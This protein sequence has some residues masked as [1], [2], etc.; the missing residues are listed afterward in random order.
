MFLKKFYQHLC[1]FSYLKNKTNNCIFVGYQNKEIL[2]KIFKKSLYFDPLLKTPFNL[3][4]LLNSILIFFTN[5][6]FNF[7]KLNFPK[8][9]FIFIFFLLAYIRINKIKKVIFLNHYDKISKSLIPFLKNIQIY[10]VEHSLNFKMINDYKIKKLSNCCSLKNKKISNGNL[11]EIGSIKLL[12]YLN[13][14]KKW[15]CNI[16]NYAKNENLEL[17]YISTTSGYFWNYAKSFNYDLNLFKIDS[18]LR[19]V[20]PLQRLENNNDLLKVRFLDNLMV[21]NII[22]KLENS[23]LNISVINRNTHGNSELFKKEKNF[24]KENFK[25]INFYEFDEASKYKFLFESKQKIF[26]TDYSYF[27]FEAFSLNNKCIFFSSY[28]KKYYKE[29]FKDELFVDER[30]DVAGISKKIKDI[31]KMNFEEILEFKEN[32]K[33]YF[34]IPEPSQNK[35]NKLKKIVLS[36]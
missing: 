35:Y 16:K 11:I 18:F 28:M 15:D 33:K 8:S 13:K 9:Q 12:Y 1:S 30:T 36:N 20:K 7:K 17:V 2:K 24:Y 23:G 25:K 27:G 31:C 19:S 6:F 4:I 10:F 32:L 34:Y 29:F 14:F 3:N 26:I 22:K 5:V 21:L